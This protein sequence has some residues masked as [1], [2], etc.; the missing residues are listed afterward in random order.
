MCKSLLQV[1]LGALEKSVKE[2][3]S[4]KG[5]IQRMHQRLVSAAPCAIKVRSRES[6][7]KKAI[8]SLERDLINGPLGSM[9]SAVQISERKRHRNPP[10]HCHNQI[11]FHLETLADSPQLQADCQQGGNIPT[12]P[13]P[14]MMHTSVNTRN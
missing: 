14:K 6:D 10:S 1:L 9:T 4:Y 12:K 11:H 13:N 7:C 3:P 2:N 5:V 8:K